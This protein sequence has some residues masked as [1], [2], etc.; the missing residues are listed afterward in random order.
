MQLE[1]IGERTWKQWKRCVKKSILVAGYAAEAHSAFAKTC[2]KKGAAKT[3]YQNI[4]EA[5]KALEPLGFTDLEFGILPMGMR[6]RYCSIS[7][8]LSMAI[9]LLQSCR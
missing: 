6:S 2:I 4:A 5:R 7:R 8:S 3:Q 1:F 9:Q